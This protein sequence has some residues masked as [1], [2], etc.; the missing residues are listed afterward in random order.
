MFCVRVWVL[1]HCVRA[2][3]IVRQ[4][5]RRFFSLFASLKQQTIA[6]IVFLTAH[7]LTPSLCG[8]KRNC[9]WLLS[10]FRQNALPDGSLQLPDGCC[11]QIENQKCNS[12]GTCNTLSDTVSKQQYLSFNVI[13]CSL[14]GW[15]TSLRPCKLY[16]KEEN[17]V[18]TSVHRFWTFCL[19]R[20]R[21]RPTNSIWMRSRV[22]MNRFA[23]HSSRV[24]ETSHI[25]LAVNE[26]PR[27]AWYCT[28]IKRRSKVPGL[29]YCSFPLILKTIWQ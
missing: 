27:S 3:T 29:F 21:R 4:K 2:S 23:L 1:A 24:E 19:Q 20:K 12:S 15:W 8:K 13:F 7:K 16:S 25:S 28:A 14:M 18:L 11:L 10:G 17:L 9:S 26:T 22:P 6:P 5:N